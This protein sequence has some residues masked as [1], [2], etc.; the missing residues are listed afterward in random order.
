M[1]KIVTTIAA[2]AMAVSMFAADVSAKVQLEGN[3]LT[4]KDG[5]ITALDI[6]KP[7]AQHWNPIMKFAFSGDKAGAE[8]AVFTGDIES[9]S[10]NKG[11]QVAANRF[12]LWMSPADGLKL[13]F[14]LNG[15]NLNQETIT[16]SKT[17]SGVEDYGYGINYSNNGFALDF[18]L[19]PGWGAS[20]LTKGKDADAVIGKTAA[21]VEYA[22]DFGKVNAILV[23]ENTFDAL[24]FGAGY[25][26][27]FGGINMFFNALGQTNAEG[28]D[29]LR[30]ELWLAGAIDAFAWKLFP[31]FNIYD[32]TK[33]SVMD[34]SLLARA[35]YALDGV[36]VYLIIGPDAAAQQNYFG[37]G[38]GGYFGL[39]NDKFNLTVQPGVSGNV[40]GASWDVGVKFDITKAGTAVSVPLILSL[41]F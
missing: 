30:F 7:S 38:Q 24:K 26:N 3:L 29:A 27:T 41:G 17:G 31:A 12:K 19:L 21:K 6:N 8:F 4:V 35:D 40:G 9:V 1:K 23:A 32:M 13:I 28:L 22:A 20:W 16:Y 33:E 39:N 36:N 2:L 18:A 25:N 14:G 5:A 37:N 34:I 11:F 10:W 15:F